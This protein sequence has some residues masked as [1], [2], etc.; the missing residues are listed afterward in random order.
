[1]TKKE[2]AEM[3]GKLSHLA[4]DIVI[5]DFDFP[6]YANGIDKGFHKS[7]EWQAIRF[8]T[9]SDITKQ[10]AEI[11]YTYRG[12]CYDWNCWYLLELPKEFFNNTQ[13]LKESLE[14]F[15]SLGS[16]AAKKLLNKLTK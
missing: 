13:K 2:A 7:F 12:E 14:L 8:P 1:M 6:N 11:L 15:S 9:L 16:E 10:E 4:M 5:W 3:L